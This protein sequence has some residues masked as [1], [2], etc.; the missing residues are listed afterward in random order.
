MFVV[1]GLVIHYTSSFDAPFMVVGGLELFGGILYLTIKCLIP[2]YGYKEPEV[3]YEGLSD[4]EIVLARQLAKLQ[5]SD[6]LRTR[7]RMMSES[8]A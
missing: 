3:E 1:A 4:R 7:S 2:K 8:F 6:G 5:R